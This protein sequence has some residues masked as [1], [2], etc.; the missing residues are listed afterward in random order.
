MSVYP[1]DMSDTQTKAVLFCS[2]ASASSKPSRLLTLQ[3]VKWLDCAN[4]LRLVRSAKNAVAFQLKLDS[5][6]REEFEIV[7]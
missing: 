2:L 3:K 7:D 1:S 6:R 4:L 5:M